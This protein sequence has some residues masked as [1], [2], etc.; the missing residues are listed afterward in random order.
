VVP[1]SVLALEKA[2]AWSAARLCYL[3][4]Q[5]VRRKAKVR[6]ARAIT[7]VATISASNMVVWCGWSIRWRR[8]LYVSWYRYT[9]P[10]SFWRDRIWRII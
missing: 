6:A 4:G 1:P 9:C 3:S 7:T 5:P 8:C 10:Q 2:G